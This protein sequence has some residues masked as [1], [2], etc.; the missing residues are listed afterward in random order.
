MFLVLAHAAS[1]DTLVSGDDD[2]LSM[3]EQMPFPILP[4]PELAVLLNPPYNAS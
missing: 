1:A 4:A 3:R 2:L